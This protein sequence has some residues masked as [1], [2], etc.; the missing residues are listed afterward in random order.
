MSGRQQKKGLWWNFP[1]DHPIVTGTINVKGDPFGKDYNQSFQLNN[2]K[3]IGYKVFVDFVGD[4]TKFDVSYSFQKTT[5]EAYTSGWNGNRTDTRGS[6][7][8][9][10]HRFNY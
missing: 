6:F 2:N 4:F 7:F 1:A 10:Y 9:N 8:R 5:A 3:L